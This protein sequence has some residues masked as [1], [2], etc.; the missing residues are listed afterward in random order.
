MDRTIQLADSAFLVNTASQTRTGQ[1]AKSQS[2]DRSDFG[3]MV[4]QKQKETP[5]TQKSSQKP[6]QQKSG[7]ADEKPAAQTSDGEANTEEKEIPDGQ[8]IL[9]AALM[10][11]PGV[12]F[13]DFRVEDSGPTQ[14]QTTEKS[15]V[16]E[17]EVEAVDV[18]PVTEEQAAPVEQPVFQQREET[19]PEEFRAVEHEVLRRDEGVVE[20]AQEEQTEET[21]EVEEAV[22][23]EQP[24]FTNVQAA[25]V[26]VAAPSEPV[27]IQAPDATE[28]LATRI[29]HV[30]VSQEDVSRV[31]FTLVPANLGKISVEI[32]RGED[33]ALH[34]ALSATTLRAAQFLDRNSGGL[35]T[36]LTN[37]SR[38]TVDV[39]VRSSQET[40]QQFLNPN[41]EGQQQQQQQQNQQ[42]QQRQNREQQEQDSRNFVQQLRLGLREL[43]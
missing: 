32:T 17:I 6:Q 18:K 41:G 19:A 25:P 16:P 15:F 36:I 5:D 28:Q 29:E 21:V 34:I 4:R 27:D 37:A 14:E 42:Q 11:Q 12:Q 3:S 8:Y 35:Q 20:Q 30:L 1:T 23:V 40:Q 13:M 10:L 31:E 7:Q 2:K 22:T 24:V 33:G 26:R 38:P 9:A 39:E 43:S